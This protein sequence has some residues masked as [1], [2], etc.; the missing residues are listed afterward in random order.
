MERII[1]KWDSVKILAT[2][3]IRCTVGKIQSL[4]RKYI[5]K[6]NGFIVKWKSEGDE[7]GNEF[8]DREPWK[9]EFQI[10]WLTKN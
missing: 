10:R 4:V 7:W 2:R 1:T 9:L 6:F 8:K 3:K 5:W